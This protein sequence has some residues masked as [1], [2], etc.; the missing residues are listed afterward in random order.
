MNL[1]KTIFAHYAPKGSQD[2][3]KDFFLA[4]NN[5]EAFNFVDS[6][7]CYGRWLEFIEETLADEDYST[8]EANE[9]AENFKKEIIENK[10]EIDFQPEGYYNLSE[11]SGYDGFTRYGWE[12]AKE[13]IS[14]S[15][16]ALLVGLKIIQ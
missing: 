1:Y 12:L 16:I 14:E 8:E 9:I 10:G 15:E 4:K 6:E 13:N 7:H 5:E 2:G 3:I 11:G